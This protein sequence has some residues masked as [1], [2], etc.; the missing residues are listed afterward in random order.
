MNYEKQTLPPFEKR[1]QVV[2]HCPCGKSNKDGKF[3]PYIEYENKG[4]CHGCGE[5]FLPE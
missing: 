4:Y 1:R 3:V 5:T 2:K